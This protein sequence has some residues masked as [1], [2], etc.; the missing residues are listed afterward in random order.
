M[1]CKINSM[2][3]P[4]SLKP[5]LDHNQRLS[6][7][8]PDRQTSDEITTLFASLERLGSHS[9]S[10]DGQI[11]A[12]LWFRNLQADVH[13][14]PAAGGFPQRITFDRP[15]RS[16]WL[17]EAPRW[18]PD[19][20]TLAFASGSRV[21][22]SPASGSA[23]PRAL[24]NLIS[25][26][27]SPRWMPD[28]ASLVVGVDLEDYNKLVQV[29]VDGAWLRQLTAGTGDDSDPQPAPDGSR[30]VFVH[31]P[32]DDMSRLD[33]RLLDLSTGEI[34]LLSGAPEKMDWMP[35]WSPDGKT[36]AYL[37]NQSGHNE[38]WMLNLEENSPYQL[39]HTRLDL[40]RHCLVARWPLD[41]RHPQPG[42]RARPFPDRFR[43][44]TPGSSPAPRRLPRP[45]RLVAAGRLYHL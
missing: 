8:R 14:L 25:G 9:L 1:C 5:P 19:G 39:T 30:L 21:F 18:S 45:T 34:Q 20:S 26:A 28:G 22:L 42:W 40:K 12:F 15:P 43:R 36:L 11:I 7:P 6:L 4:F 35:R 10:P 32:A 13:T 33:L 29:S 27:F 2:T 41:R 37:S 16:P 3:N 31:R 23:A 38:L 24:S 44:R 17:E